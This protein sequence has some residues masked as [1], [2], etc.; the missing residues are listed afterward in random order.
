MLTTIIPIE[1]TKLKAL[2]TISFTV[3]L[4]PAMIR[5]IRVITVKR[6][7]SVHEKGNIDIGE[8]I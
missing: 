2:S 4:Y 1:V 7:H 5:D 3:R 8:T 6:I